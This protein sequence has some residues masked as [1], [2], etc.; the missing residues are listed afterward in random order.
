MADLITASRAIQNAN[1]ATL[2]T[3]NPDYLASL[4]TAASVAIERACGRVFGT[5]SYREYLSGPR[6]QGDA[7]RLSHYPVL[8][9]SRVAACPT[10]A[11][12][13]TNT[14]ST[15]NQR[16]TVATTDTALILYRMASGTGTTTTLAFASY[17][18]LATLKTAIEAA[19]SGWQVTVNGGYEAWPTTEL[20]PMQ[21]A[22]S[23][24][25]GTGADLEIYAEDFTMPW[26]LD[27]GSGILWGTFPHGLNNIRVD[28]TAGYATIPE[29]IQQATVLLVQHL[30]QLDKVQAGV[31]S[32]SIG[33]YSRTFAPAAATA[34]MP[35]S[36][37]SMI[38][39][40]VDHSRTV[41]RE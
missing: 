38:A 35:S 31:Q 28:Y 5:A 26:R 33:P 24:M 30:Y 25:A 7:L 13:V 2:N 32:V 12:C 29:D 34:A 1:L 23:A 9:I 14:A 40:Y 10:R 4:I 41:G 22:V 16:A 36:V 39:R 15:T 20:A 18:T 3:A 19:G 8:S 17:G 37:A 6:Y 11:L 27:A 21:G